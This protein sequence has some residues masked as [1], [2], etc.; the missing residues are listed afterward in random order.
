MWSLN[1]FEFCPNTMPHIKRYCREEK[2]S[3]NEKTTSNLEKYLIKKTL[4]LSLEISPEKLS[5]I[6]NNK[7]KNL[8]I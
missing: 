2:I 6:K 4:I 1:L 5:L 7:I 8:I 3:L